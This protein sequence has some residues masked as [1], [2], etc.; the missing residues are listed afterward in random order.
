VQPAHVPLKGGAVRIVLQSLLKRRL[1][2]EVQAGEGDP[3]WWSSEAGVP[4]ALRVTEAGL[5]AIGPPEAPAP[6]PELA[7]PVPSAPAETVQPKAIRSGTKQAALIAL[8]QRKEGATVDE[9]VSAT[10]WL[11]H[12]VRGAMAGALKKRL[13][14]EITSEKV[15]VGGEYTGP[16]RRTGSTRGR[17]GPER[18]DSARVTRVLSSR[19]AVEDPPDMP[20]PTVR[21]DDR[22]RA[23]RLVVGAAGALLAATAVNYLLARRAERNHP[24]TGRFIEV[25]GVRLHVKEYGAGEPL[26]LIHGNGSAIEELETS[27]LIALAARTHRVI[28]VD[29]PGYGHSARPRGRLYTARAQ[30]KLMFGALRTLG[31][32]RATVF[33]HSWGALVALE[34]A[35][36]HPECVRKL[37][38]ASGYYYPTARW[39]V[40]P[41]SA[42]ALPVLGTVLRHTIAPLLSRL[43]WPLLI[44]RIFA[45]S[46][47]PPKFR[48]YSREMAARPSQLQASAADTAL[49]IPG[50]AAAAH[51]YQSLSVPVVII[52][53]EDDRVCDVN[54][55]AARLHAEIPGSVIHRL[56]GAGH[57][58][59]QTRTRDVWAAVEGAGGAV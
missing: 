10:G 57:M 25:Y 21:S 16:D 1:L 14:L 29:R 23:F 31:V 46:P 2:G 18:N 53:G 38:V 34:L 44:R 59:H 56:S 51:K 41:L 8:L 7:A 26:L 20:V 37:V 55:H 27:G 39:E 9:M 12:T 30:A 17:S 35:A 47:V 3:V 43:L 45:P 5:D 48:G 58:I 19:E 40:P 50:A 24:P 15:R 49:M 6:M 11:S 54:D 32:T 22:A 13:G 36:N 28:A 4:L 33:G 42:P 52:A